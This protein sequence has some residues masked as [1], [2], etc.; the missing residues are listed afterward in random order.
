MMLLM[1]PTAFF[2]TSL[3]RAKACSCV[4]SLPINSSSFSFGTTMRRGI[5][6]S[7]GW[8]GVRSSAGGMLRVPAMQ[9][10]RGSPPPVGRSLQHPS[11]VLRSRSRQVDP[12]SE[13]R[14]NKLDRQQRA[15][16]SDIDSSPPW[17]ALLLRDRF[18]H[19]AAATDNVRAAPRAVRASCPL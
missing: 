7:G 3:A 15:S 1:P 5:A 13:T 6:L 19:I 16:A 17:T 18:G 2:S 4:T 8:Q 11:R 9:R 12:F 14:C 10:R